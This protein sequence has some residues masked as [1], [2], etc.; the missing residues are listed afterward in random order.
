M[1]T[2]DSKPH[3]LACVDLAAKTATCSVCGPVKIRVRSGNRGHE[4]MTVRR[5]AKQGYRP[6]DAARARRRRMAQYGLTVDAYDALLA[7]QGGCCAICG[8]PPGKRPLAVDHD[9]ETGDVRGLLC[10]PCNTG[11]GLFRDD[12]ERL[13]AAAAYLDATT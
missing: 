2:D 12:L 4:C 11:L 9:H 3:R 6:A 8:D 10:L 13:A 1:D 5:R 7:E